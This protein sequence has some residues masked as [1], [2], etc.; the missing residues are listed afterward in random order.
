MDA[1]AYLYNVWGRVRTLKSE[2][3]CVVVVMLENVGME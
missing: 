3:N 2:L 1:V